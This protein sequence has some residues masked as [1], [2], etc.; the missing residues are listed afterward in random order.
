MS[1][2]TVILIILFECSLRATNAGKSLF[3]LLPQIYLHVS[4]IGI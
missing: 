3:K 4:R 2:M 1:T